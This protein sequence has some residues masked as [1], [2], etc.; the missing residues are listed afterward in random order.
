MKK[1]IEIMAETLV[2][3]VDGRTPESSKPRVGTKPSAWIPRGVKEVE[4]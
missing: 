3:W 1:G 4:R 2:P